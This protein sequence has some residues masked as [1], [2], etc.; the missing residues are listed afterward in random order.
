MIN[1]ILYHAAIR[2]Y[3]EWKEE[4]AKCKNKTCT[5]NSKVRTA[6]VA[7]EERL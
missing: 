4:L 3:E 5:H 7:L 1:Y 2:T 6:I